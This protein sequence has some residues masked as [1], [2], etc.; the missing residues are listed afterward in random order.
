MI[1]RNK[2]GIGSMRAR[3]AIAAAVLVGGGAA[4]AVALS[5]HGST[6]TAQS[7]GYTTNHHQTLSEGIALSEAFSQW[8]SSPTRS[9]NTLSDM[10]KMRTFSQTWRHHVQFA[11]QR[12][13]VLLATKKFLV[14]KSFNGSLHLWWLTGNTRITDVS[15]TT[16]G[17]LAMTGSTAATTQAMTFNNMT[18]ATNVMVGS[19]TALTQMVTPTVKPV[20]ITIAT[21]T[22]TITI[23]VA[24][25]TAMV[26]A[27]T[28]MMTTQTTSFTQPVFK[29]TMGIQRGDLVFVAGTRRHGELKAQLVLFAAPLNVMPTPTMS[30][31]P[32]VSPSISSSAF[33]TA[34]PTVSPSASGTPTFTGKSS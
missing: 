11:V 5:A 10:T 23:T 29:A 27:P 9:F 34:T 3:L 15:S 20:T 7:A 16:S 33:P 24:S 18:P 12:G 14:V 25:T 2:R 26:T 13:V 6:A 31:T 22:V 32:T 19:T 28:A 21:G 4:G 17:M 30:A 8:N 1:D